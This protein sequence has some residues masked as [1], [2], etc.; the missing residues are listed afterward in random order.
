MSPNCARLS[1]PSHHEA[2][3]LCSS[4]FVTAC[5]KHLDF[6]DFP[7]QH[8]RKSGLGWV[9]ILQY[10]SNYPS[11]LYRWMK[12]IG[13]NL[14]LLRFLTEEEAVLE[15]VV[16]VDQKLVAASDVG[17]ARN[18]WGNGLIRAES[19]GGCNPAGKACSQDAFDHKGLVNTDFAPGVMES[20][21][22]TYPSTCGTSVYFPF[23][24]DTHVAAV[25]AWFLRWACENCSV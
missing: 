9:G 1:E 10:R 8:L 13:E 5:S 18:L 22:S 19:G 20:G 7:R 24:E 11:M 17:C 12:R 21:T 25:M 23:S 3:H 14:A 15:G 16:G 4:P 2:F 6:V